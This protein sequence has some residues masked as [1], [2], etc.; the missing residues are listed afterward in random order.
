[1]QGIINIFGD[2][3]VDT[4]LVS[5]IQQVKK[6][7][8]AD[9]FIVN[10][11]SPGGYV[12]EGF[13]IHDYLKDLPYPI[14]TRGRGVVASIATVIFMAGD[15]RSVSEG[16]NFMIHMPY[17]AQIQNAGSDE[18]A[19][20]SAELKQIEKRLT[21]FYSKE[22]EIG[23]ASIKAMLTSET[24][25]SAVQLFD[26]GFTTNKGTHKIEAKL[27]TNNKMTEKEKTEGHNLLKQIKKLFNQYKATNKILFAANEDEVEF[28][29]VAEDEQ[30]KVG[31]TVKV[32]GQT[33]EDGDI[34][35]KDG[36]VIT[37][38]NGKIDS[39]ET[40]EEEEV[41][42]EDKALLSVDGDIIEFPDVA[43]DADIKVG[44]T[45]LVNDDQ[46]ADGSITLTDGRILF[47]V[48]GK[49]ESIT[50]VDEVLEE[51][52]NLRA[53]NKKMTSTLRQVE[54]FQSKLL[55]EKPINRTKGQG[56]VNSWSAAINQ[57]KKNK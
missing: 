6:Q 30:I 39:I 55:Q 4:T 56:H 2:I 35:L 28:P 21:D 12:D 57:L 25:L 54:T 41:V 9:S 24:T 10:I 11:D 16:T 53:I 32:N 40:P 44:D 17:V 22:T 26:L 36:R 49:I 37:V 15:T 45:V 52:V 46:P 47:V 33:P 7:P 50:N 34:T 23:E 42:V 48:A 19:M 3:G 29:D 13:D 27:L 38:V 5:V 51:V 43:E 18:L 1:M 31:D 8:D 14:H 20:L